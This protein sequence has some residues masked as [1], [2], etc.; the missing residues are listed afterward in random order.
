MQARGSRA[1][2]LGLERALAWPLGALHSVL[3]PQKLPRSGLPELQVAGLGE[4]RGLEDENSL[5]KGQG[6]L[7][8]ATDRW[9][10]EWQ[11]HDRLNSVE[12][13]V[14]GQALGEI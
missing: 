11:V 1:Q 10:I 3:C 6:L 8:A 7:E 9:L 13:W 14:S 2:S 5:R 12:G 4:R